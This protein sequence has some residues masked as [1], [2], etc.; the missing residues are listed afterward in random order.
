[1]PGLGEKKS[2]PTVRL[3]KRRPRY[4]T[5]KL[6]DHYYPWQKKFSS[7]EKEPPNKTYGDNFFEKLC[8]TL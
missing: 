1:M 7:I 3:R 6:T 4:L 8:V 2:P 5:H